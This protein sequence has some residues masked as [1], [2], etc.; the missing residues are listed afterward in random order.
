MAA[1]ASR[2]HGIWAAEQKEIRCQLVC[3]L[4]TAGCPS[5]QR[6]GDGSV[7]GAGSG[8]LGSLSGSH[9]EFATQTQ[10]SEARISLTRCRADGCLD[11]NNWLCMRGI[12]IS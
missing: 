7:P 5:G 10:W 11:K 3:S 6:L 2:R 1:K 12:K 9:R 4:A 8:P